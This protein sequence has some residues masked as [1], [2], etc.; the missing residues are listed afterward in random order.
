LEVLESRLAPATFNWTGAG[1]NSNWSTGANWSGGVAPTGSAAAL[2]D[3]VFSAS[4]SNKTAVN[5]FTSVPTFN[6]ITIA[7]SNYTLSGKQIALGSSSASGSG[8]LIV[9]QGAANETISLDMKLGGAGGG[10]QFFTINNGADLTISGKLSGSTGVELTKEGAGKLTLGND[11]SGF[12][13]PI[14]VDDNS[15]I[16]IITNNKAL[17][18]SSSGTTIGTNSQLQ[19]NNVTGSIQEGLTL[20]GTGIS[21][22]GALLSVAGTNVWAGTV[23]LASDGLIGVNS[24]TLEISGQISDLGSGHNVTK[25]GAG[26][27]IFSAAN[28][29]RGSTTIIN[30]ILTVRNAQALGTS[31]GTAATGTL[32]KNNP[33]SGTGTLQ[34]EDPTG[35]G[36]TIKDEFLTLN[37]PGY[38]GAG[39]LVNVNGINHWAGSIVLGSAGTNGTDVTIGVTAATTT[40]PNTDLYLDGVISDPDRA[41]TNLSKISGG[42]LILTNSNTF[43]GAT[44]I[45]GGV[46]NIRDSEALGPSTQRTV[47]IGGTSG[48]F[49]L[50]YNGKSTSALQS[51]ATA[52][53]VQAALNGLSTIG[54]VGGSVIV[55]LNGSTYTITFGGSLAGLTTV[56]LTANGSG[57]ATTTVST[58]LNSVTVG[59]GSALEMQV[60]TG[61][62][63]HNRDLSKDSVTGVG[64]ELAMQLTVSINGTGISSGGALRSVSGINTWVAGTIG[65][66]GNSAA[67]GVDPDPNPSSTNAYFTNDYSLTV[68]SDISGGATLVKVGTGQLILPNAND[69]TSQTQI[70]Q[71]WITIQNNMSLGAFVNGSDPVQPAVV[72]SSGAALHLKPSA[73][74]V[75]INLVKNMVLSGNGITH[76]FGLISQKGALMTLGGA[77]TI[78]G[79]NAA[80]RTS[81]IQ[82]NGNAGIG[83]EEVDPAYGAAVPSELTITA[84]IGDAAGGTA[85]GI[86]KLG[87][88][89]LI[90]QGIGTYTGDVLIQEGV[91][92][93]QGDTALGLGTT[94]TAATGNNSYTT[95]NTTVG[96]GIGEVQTFTVGGSSGTF[97]LTFN[98]FTTGPLAF[99][100]PGSGGTGST[101][102]VQN[103]LNAL[104]SI[105]GTGGTVTVNQSSS[106][107]TVMFGGKFVGINQ[108]QLVATGSGGASV[109]VATL[110]DG[111]G[112]ALEL[113][114]A[115]PA[116][117]GGIA[118][119]I[120]VFNE[121]LTLSGTGNATFGDSV[122]NVLSQGDSMWRGPVSL[123]TSAVLQ[124]QPGSRIILFGAIDDTA[125][126]SPGGSDLTL[127]GGGNLALAGANSYRGTTFVNQGILEILSSQAL[128][129]TGVAEVQTVTMG[130]STSGTF[131]LSFNGALTSSLSAGA[132]AAQVQ[133]ALNALP[134]IGGAGGSVTVSLAGKVYT[135][136]FGGQLL[137]FNQPTIV[138]VG[139]GGATATV[140]TVVNGGGGTVVANGASL[141]L[142]GSLTVAG[143]PL[144]VQGQ[145]LAQD[146]NLPE[147]WFAIG[148]APADNGQTDGTEAVTGR[149]TGIVTDPTDGNIIYITTA[150]GG[151]WKTKDGGKTWQPLFDQRGNGGINEVQ[152]VTLTGNTGGFTLSFAGQSTGSLSATATAAQVQSALNS[153]STIGGVGGS[154]T[155]TLNAGVYTITF[156]GTF[157]GYNVPSMTASGSGGTTATAAT[158]TDGGPIIA[159]E[160][161]VVTVTGNSGNFT[162]SFNG[163]T[164]ASLAANATAAQIQTALNNLTTI[165]G[166]N[167]SVTV[168][169]SNGVYNVTFGGDLR[170][171]DLPLM[172]AA[173]SGGA[174][175][176]VAAFADGYGITVENQ[177]LGVANASGSYTLT[178]AGQTTSSLAFNATAAQVQSALNALS[179]IGGI[180]GSVVVTQPPLP[181][182]TVDFGGPNVGTNQPQITAQGS[183]GASVNVTTVSDGAKVVTSEVQVI[184]ITGTTGS[185]TLSFTNGST[186]S[187]TSSITN[188]ASA[189]TVQSAL[190]NLQSIRGNFGPPRAS[191]SVSK[192]GTDYT[193][194]FNGGN[195]NG[196]NVNSISGTGTGGTSVSVTTTT[197]GSTTTTH[198]VQRITVNGSAGTFTLSFN[199]DTTGSLAYNSTAQQV[200][201]AIN[202]LNGVSNGSNQ[203]GPVSVSLAPAP[204]FN[205]AFGGTLLGLDVPLLTADGDAG[206][207]VNPVSDGFGT[208][209]GVQAFSVTGSS[210]TFTLSFNGSVT[211]SLPFNATA[212]QVQTA[213]NSLAS[214]G[215]VDGSVGVT[216]T[217]S[218][219]VV[220]FY[221]N[222]AGN[223]LP[224]LLVTGSGGTTASLVLALQGVPQD[225]PMY[226]NTIA[227]DPSDSRTLYIGTG[228][229][230]NS[231]DSY[232][233]TGIYKSTDAGQ[234]WTLL[235]DSTGGNPLY[236]KGVSKIAF[237]SNGNLFAAVGDGGSGRNEVQTLNFQLPN[238][239]QTFTLTFTGVD[240]TGAVMS[241]TTPDITWDTSRSNNNSQVATDI[242]TDLNALANI[243]GVG[244]LV[245]VTAPSGGR[246]GGGGSFT[247]TFSGSLA[248]TNVQQ[249]TTNW[250]VPSQGVPG[251]AVGTKVDGGPL[252]VVNGTPGG[253]GIWRL[254]KGSWFNLTSVVSKNRSS[255]AST[256]T[257]S[258]PNPNPPNN[259]GP[260]DN[261][262][263]SFP[264]TGVTWSDVVVVGSKLYAALGNGAGNANDGV[265][266]TTDLTS[267]TPVWYAADPTNANPSPPPTNLPDGR[268]GTEFST[269]AGSIKLSATGSTV[270]A[271][272]ATGT[273]GLLGVYVTTDGGLNWKSVTTSPSNYFSAQGAYANA[274]LA[275]GNTIYVAGFESSSSSH[276]S[277][278][279]RSTDGGSSWTDISVDSN[280]NSPHSAVHTLALDSQ[281]RLLVGTD[282]GLWRLESNST[283]TDLNGNLE[284]MQVNYVASSPTDLNVVYAASQSNGVEKFGGSLAWAYIDQSNNS[285]TSGGGPI[286][287]DPV[288]PSNLYYVQY[289]TSAN[290]VVRRS[291]DSGATWSTVLSTTRSTAPLVLDAVKP[292]RL[293]AGGASLVESTNSGTSWTNLNNPLS[294]ITGIAISTYQGVF[295]AD[296]DFSQ[297]IDQGANTYD[298]N[299]IYATDGN[300]VYVTKDHGQTWV[301]RT[302][303]LLGFGGIQDIEVD[304]RNRDVIY[305]VRKFFGS[306]HVYRS[307]D[308]GQTWTDISGNLPN[309]PVWKLVID[310]REGDPNAANPTYGDIYIGTDQGVYMLPSGSDTWHRVGAG[311]PNVQVHDLQLN[312]TTNVLLAATYGRGV[313]QLF[314]EQG[315][316][317]S[318]AFSAV[319]GNSVWTGPVIFA[320]DTTINASG[321]QALQNGLSTAQLTIV[322]SVTEIASGSTSALTKIGG[323]NL[324]LSGVNT[325]G[326]I[327]E[328]QGGVLVVH[329]SKA[330][331]SS[332]AGTIVDAGTSL[333]LQSN[334]DLEPITLNGDG[335]PNPYNGHNTGALRNLSNNNVYTGALTLNIA[336]TIGV[337]T[338]SS[339]TIASPGSISGGATSSLTKELAGTLVLANDN[340]YAGMTQVNQGVLQIQSSQALGGTTNG[341][342]I[343]D[344]AQLQMQAPSGGGPVVVGSE[345]LSLSG[346]GIFG[347]GALLD[348]GGKNTWNGPI[349]LGSDPA[350]FPETAPAGAVAIGVTKAADQ[351]TVGALS[352]SMVSGLRKVGAGKL[353]LSQAD[354]Y[355]GTTYVDGGIL[356]VQNTQ[357]LGGNSTNEVQRIT[358]GGTPGTFT[359]TFNGQTTGS[360][361]S[362]VP[363][364]GGTGAT[365][366]VQNALN[367]LS[368]IGGVGGSV[369]VTLTTVT[370][371]TPSGTVSHN[372]YTVTF[373]GSLAG[374]N[375]LQLVAT[376]SGGTTATA[377]TVADGGI[378]TQVASGAALQLDGDPTNLGGGTGIIISGESLILNGTGNSNAGALENVTGANTWTGSVTL[379]TDT[380]IG[381]DA[382]TQLT[383]SGVVQDPS[384]L[385]NPV[386][387]L[388]KVGTG[389]LVL[390]N[391]NTYSGKTT[392]N[393][394]ILNIRDKAAL[395]GVSASE[396]QQLVVGG[397]NSG[398]FTLTFNG[399]TTGSLAYNVP[400][401]GGT[402]ATASVQNALNALSTV[403]GVSG[404]VAVT[405][406]GTT[407]TVT[408]GGSLALTSLPLITAA[409]ANGTT[410]SVS[411]LTAGSGGTTVASGATLQLQANN[412]VFANEALTLSGLG[413]NGIG[414]LDDVAGN[415]STWDRAISLAANASIGVDGSSDRLIIDQP[416]SDGGK[417]FG[418][419]KIGPGTLQYA[420]S[421]GNS[422]TGLTTVNQGPL[423]LN[424]SGG[425]IA[426]AGDLTVGDNVAG[427]AS[428]K[429]LTAGDVASTSN[430]IVN[431][432][433][434]FDLNGLT[435]T[436]ASLTMNGGQVSLTGT[437]SKLT[438]GGD[439]KGTNN[440]KITGAGT[441]SL[442]GATRTFTVTPGSGSPD[443]LVDAV[444]AGVNSTD[445]LTKAGAGVLQ[446]TEDNT[447][448]GTTTVNLGTVLADGPTTGNTLAN[449]TLNG[450]TLGGKG[451]VDTI[452]STAGTVAP[453]DDS[454]AT[455]TGTL[456]SQTVTL[457]NNS[458]FFV[459]LNGTGAG[460]YD[461]LTVNGDIYLNT[462]TLD[463]ITG[464]G[465]NLL[466]KFTIITTS[467]G[468]VHGKFAEPHGSGI[469]FIGGQKYSV[470]YSDSTKVVLQRIANSLTVGLAVSHNPSNYGEDVLFTATVTPEAGAVLK[471]NSASITFELDS[472]P[473]LTK[474]ITIGATNQ[475]VFSPQT[476]IGGFLALGGHSVTATFNPNADFNSAA[477]ATASLTVG[478]ASTTTALAADVASPVYGQQIT[479][480]ATVAPVSPGAG[481][482]TGSLTFKVDG[483]DQ[484]PAATLDSNGKATLKL[485]NLSVGTHHLLA[486]YAG[487]TNYV[488]SG[489]SDLTVTIDK[490]T[491]LVVVDSGTLASSVYS[492]QVT[493][494]ATVSSVS[495]GT[496]TPSGT[497][498]FFDGPAVG[499]TPL[500]SGPL[501]INGVA[502]LK[503]STLGVTDHT[504]TA[505]YNG[506]TKVATNTGTLDFE[507]NQANTTTGMP[508]SSA[509]PG[510][511][512]D[513]V[514]YSVQV[515]ANSPAAG[516]PNGQVMFVIDSVNQAAVALNSSGVA[517]IT[518]NNLAFGPHNISATY[519]GNTNFAGSS[520]SSAL[521]E[522]IVNA[523]TVKVTAPVAGSVYGQA[524]VFTA[525]VAV[526]SPGTGTPAGF[527]QF[528]VDGV[529]Q[530]PIAVDGTGKATLSL[531]SLAAQTA[532]HTVGANYLGNAAFAASSSTSLASLV[533]AKAAV[534]AA[535]TSDH[536]TAI[537]G[538]I[539]NITAKMNPTSPGGGIP[540]GY[541]QF[542]IDNVVFPYMQLDSAGTYTMPIPGTNPL[543]GFLDTGDHTIGLNY[544]GS[545]NYNAY[546]TPTRTAQKITIAPTAGSVSSS[547][548][549]GPVGQPVTFTATVTAPSS[550][551]TPT[552][553]V[554]FVVDG[555]TRGNPVALD[556]NGKA[557]LSENDL[558]AG[559]H[560]VGFNYF[561]TLN[562]AALS[563]PAS[564]VLT[565]NAADTT[566]SVA[567]ADTVFGQPVNYVATISAKSPSTA[568]PTG[569][570]VI[571][572][573]GSA[574]TPVAI[575]PST[576]KATL[577]L[578][579]VAVM[580]HTV[581]AKY[582]G[583]TDFNASNSSGI[584]QTVSQAATSTV[585][586]TP[587]AV[588][589]LGEPVTFTA[590]VTPEALSILPASGTVTFTI[591]STGG[592]ADYPVTLGSTGKATLTRTDI[593][594]GNYTVVANFAANSGYKASTSGTLSQTIRYASSITVAS[595]GATVYGQAVTFTAT[596]KGV[597]PATATPSG[598][599]QFVVDGVATV[600]GLDING[601]AKLTRS[602]L[603]AGNHTFGADYFGDNTFAGKSTA[604]LQTQHVDPASTSLAVTSPGAIT[605]GQ[606]VTFT[607][608]ATTNA[609]G[610]GT[611]S[612]SVQFVIDGVA[613]TGTMALDNSG[614]STL[615]I[616]GLSAGTHTAGAN[617]FGSAN[618]A[619][620]STPQLWSQTVN[621]AATAT[622]GS[623]SATTV[624]VGQ[625]VTFYATVTSAAGVPTGQVTFVV[626]NVA[627]GTASVD[628]K[629]GIAT[630][631]VS[632]LA[633]GNHTVLPVY[634]GDTNYHYS[635]P[636]AVLSLTVKDVPHVADLNLAVS[637]NVM[638][639]T[640]F[641]LTVAA[642]DSGGN[643]ITND[644][645]NATVSMDSGPANA[646]L[647][648][649][650]TKALVGGQISFDDLMV[651][652]PGP[653]TL[654]VTIGSFSKTITF[655]AAG[656]TS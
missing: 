292:Q 75:S 395:G 260:D 464:N 494:K 3:L 154:V 398:S 114:S 436:V 241:Y 76:P 490:D 417:A 340:T 314:L 117:I 376:G 542:I 98:G 565:L 363:A 97:T 418:I 107:Y 256:N 176:S 562:F 101:A 407:Y 612:G 380:S 155:V 136:T 356:A 487:D 200:Q 168:A 69:Y 254:M 368:S 235:T 214:I 113:Q 531:S 212:M 255:V 59:N 120:Q 90:L 266:Y 505:Q 484:T 638:V 527:V 435:Q 406:S 54:G 633:I 218:M 138:A 316:A 364:S 405:Q 644:T 52:T 311:M 169:G 582:A 17:G 4:A 16:L 246:R 211:A 522:S 263:L 391:A 105:A 147:G 478:Q 289:Q 82:L 312:Q 353:V 370:T 559:D 604:T 592:S 330:L 65:L 498:T 445:G 103:A 319:S 611:P 621:Q 654:R 553:Y 223:G 33:V 262:L 162:L 205:I 36:F 265:Y 468:T 428:V 366:S 208:T 503:V 44:T 191:V 326:G 45:S 528:V 209:A 240:S 424:A 73:P 251:I 507:V 509:N 533:V 481:V 164:T 39:A 465:V 62:D 643:L 174:K 432:D 63:A 631:T 526:K 493:F 224:Q 280:S 488:K 156:G 122:F 295:V 628:P 79:P 573:D 244:G 95:T 78:G 642:L 268:A 40:N 83:V 34:I 584:N 238:G 328:I 387:N 586:T 357:G 637:S 15:G 49:T 24:G 369:T 629:T 131:T 457:D 123:Q 647:S 589:G 538:T 277:Q 2:D 551:P 372:V 281:G 11:N 247:I 167:G 57:G 337:D 94:G 648:G 202:Q 66:S 236:G 245:V 434:T 426:V 383:I 354:S 206:A 51:N 467:G 336:T 139:S 92:R 534:T 655:S 150:G 437:S 423:E 652:K 572:I 177:Q 306:G 358:L 512:G 448:G 283:W 634:L 545:S 146:D 25:I 525:A 500:G 460:Q 173:G 222:L 35:A 530:T 632:D 197:D 348:T 441:V 491:A 84:A 409:G 22:D 646:T 552:G 194:T 38:N 26:Q 606:S 499:G 137:G 192:S 543:I 352:E 576:G 546:S 403:G 374:V 180:G 196:V 607:V 360:L 555:Q 226:I 264:Q 272:A 313:Y 350:F 410:V 389:T 471:P 367:A 9:N 473:A 431:S 566:L 427:A 556:S 564:K 557:T 400:A 37:G 449:V 60:D 143:E 486:N 458:T 414:A 88:R 523:T 392:V 620:A 485:S 502:T 93:A 323:G 613:Q 242:Q 455:G 517:S 639:N 132:T 158:S 377:S 47:A 119:G 402:S 166:V 579:P 349:S 329:N 178:F 626:D 593:P 322:G 388:T 275:T 126:T 276:T 344:G 379:A 541:V 480:T 581:Q 1:S 635:Y 259:P 416:I 595:S 476:L 288:T 619:A 577:T 625:P 23:S 141:Q 470:D 185:F 561:G 320:G 27:L 71:G 636:A 46:V 53:Q 43:I 81:S 459:V 408:F 594:L 489:S 293:L 429:L 341:T 215:G 199:G 243:G 656:R 159:N 64:N 560:T 450:G 290:A 213:L 444:I 41:G 570:V 307:T 345:S 510:G 649:T 231:P 331:G 239:P 294:T 298:A 309:F 454:T 396:V 129:G 80:A 108:P 569:S 8:S 229:T 228:E 412:T 324:V 273:G 220:T 267:T 641:S 399:K 521:S 142:E 600:V 308:A 21:G 102:S 157:A 535:I 286:Q 334:L 70:Q 121:H 422:Y 269:S 201:D 514:V 571:Y 303:D 10:Q 420:G 315:D 597:S 145:G 6:S 302:N 234:S 127:S 32:I 438:L 148:P 153:L 540:D 536:P 548:S 501:D 321:S 48:T 335:V 430:V 447:F 355:S 513:A 479:F 258:L 605:F 558:H 568:V 439:V 347:T 547:V 100:V 216:H 627:H 472:N 58:R 618:F 596:V 386:A 300:S 516:T 602:D 116:A 183:G 299:T 297:V 19:I 411:R 20:N 362:A 433:G 351:L 282:G 651:T 495:P 390:P 175:A 219:Y 50:T 483:T 371:A 461:K 296:P 442:G 338:G 30:G 466:D 462:A 474:T 482:P 207:A 203:A 375:V 397:V 274:I 378:G 384:P 106:V 443:L 413:F 72:V 361:D 187:T 160:E 253:P 179:N 453:G 124:T 227:M 630:L 87:S 171:Q 382:G 580:T 616:S 5:D 421:S 86:T 624:T 204:F 393:A 12:T 221:D 99:N 232:Y 172:T 615:T 452:G 77:D 537:Y 237:D 144:I 645:D 550:I 578:N 415:S 149:I 385:P 301:D 463:G 104:S 327:T 285:L 622:V 601:V 125:N 270:Y 342:R 250:A 310:S 532:A 161:Q 520:S 13:G 544:L 585:L 89:R 305:A 614:K 539:V 31:D 598:N 617:F 109:T 18:D 130:G 575:D 189:S 252:K 359:L 184:H 140:A 425:A 332:S 574:Q 42:R 519:L 588:T 28:T 151:A 515:T 56:P 279:Y 61:T 440:A 317:N 248:L 85:G 112:A 524:V 508:T 7:G 650:L 165:G 591:N 190:N 404:S 492:Q 74:G 304:P 68:Q 111:D 477:P 195:L 217:G 511:L 133:A 291:T 333:E 188:G 128:G 261:Y 497:V 599:M 193:V 225:A 135:I 653:Y 373:G 67:I 325:Y 29:Y 456:S 590:T 506:D 587:V 182:Y 518:R 343:L 278:I 55:S 554:Q 529:S 567:A 198:E 210:G 118:A 603:V 451:V 186:T 475:V 381:T 257:T 287:V 446:L 339:L 115:P 271:S 365:A 583:N 610:N 496:A 419:T 170:G 401:T 623:L 549:T 563:V 230:N 609:P 181:V 318:G 469:A 640:A 233:G 249:L 110:V 394:G 284:T 152:T 163:Q 608:T 96:T 91:L 134:T 346:T 14:T 504:I